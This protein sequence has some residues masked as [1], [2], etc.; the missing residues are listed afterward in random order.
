MWYISNNPPGRAEFHALQCVGE[1]IGD[2]M[3]KYRYGDILKWPWS[4]QNRVSYSMD[5]E[6]SASYPKSWR[7]GIYSQAFSEDYKNNAGMQDN[8]I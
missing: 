6:I 4:I 1:W 2:D 3:V 8:R 5:T 7:K